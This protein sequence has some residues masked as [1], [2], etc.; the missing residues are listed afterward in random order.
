[1]PDPLTPFPL[2]ALTGLAPGD[3]AAFARLAE[4]A[5]RHQVAHNPV[6]AAF[7]EGHDWQSWQQAPYLPVEAF[8]L[9]DVAAFDAKIAEAMYESSGTGQGMPA[10]RP[11]ASLHWEHKLSE[12]A[13][14]RALGEGPFVIAAHLPGYAE[15]GARSSLVS[16]T[17]H[18]IERFGAPGSTFFLEDPTPFEAAIASSAHSGTPLLLLGAAFGL[19]D[20]V[21]RRTWALPPGARVIETGGM[22]THRREIGRADLHARL[23][24][25]FG[26][27][28]TQVGSEY[29]MCELVSQAWAVP[30]GGFMPPPWLRVRVVDPEDP[31]RALPDGEV[32]QLALC[33]LGGV[34]S[35][36]FLLTEDQAILEG[37]RFRVLGRLPRASLRGCNFL[38]ES[39]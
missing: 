26:V 18:L 10:H 7:A 35:C 17:A 2:D 30:G 6:Y 12:E 22:K 34:W 3:E 23:A 19:L 24:G 25:G 14:L 32:G 29:G 11:V 9:T 31:A 37:D 27:A 28:A 38:M 39:F 5:F 33:D 13:F 4:A 16:M 8:R 36:P 21:E 15:R 20:L 1:M